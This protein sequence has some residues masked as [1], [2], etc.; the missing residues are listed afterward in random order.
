MP[1]YKDQDMNKSLN[2][3]DDLFPPSRFDELMVAFTELDDEQ[4]G[5]CDMDTMMYILRNFRSGLK[6]WELPVVRSLLKAYV[7]DQDRVVYLDICPL[8]TQLLN[9][10]LWEGGSYLAT[11][12][13]NKKPENEKKDA[14]ESSQTKE[15]V[16]SK[17]NAIL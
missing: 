4:S 6:E 1:D 9:K 11:P 14:K 13:R 2:G 7:D 17:K 3:K 5:Y 15:T 16:P 12:E 8:L 10:R